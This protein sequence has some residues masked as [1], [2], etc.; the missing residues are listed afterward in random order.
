MQTTDG[1]NMINFIDKIFFV[2]NFQINNQLCN[3]MEWYSLSKTCPLELVY[4][5]LPSNKY[6]LQRGSKYSLVSK[7][8]ANLKVLKNKQFPKNIILINMSLTSIFFESKII[9][10]I[11]PFEVHEI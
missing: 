8:T 5:P 1:L 4:I 7:E 2:T 6:L 10:K 9:I 11:N 3:G